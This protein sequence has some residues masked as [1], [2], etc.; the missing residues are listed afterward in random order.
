LVEEFDGAA[1][2]LA[3]LV[4]VMPVLPRGLLRLGDVE[5]GRRV[6]L[7]VHEAGDDEVRAHPEVD[8]DP[9]PLET[10]EPGR[11]PAGL[12]AGVADVPRLLHDMDV[13]H[14]PGDRLHP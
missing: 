14:R 11:A 4:V 5:S 1:S 8:P 6:D 13:A 12:L 7:V 2:A 3:E 10:T 9:C